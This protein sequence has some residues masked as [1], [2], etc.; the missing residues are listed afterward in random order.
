MKA[1][2]ILAGP[3]R[4]GT[5]AKVMDKILFGLKDKGAEVE[6]LSLYDYDIKPCT[7]CCACE[8]SRECFIEDDHRMILDKMAD[9]DV[10]IFASP[11]YWSNVTSEAKKF[12]DRGIGFFEQG[13][14][15]PVRRES[16]PGK[17]VLISSC[18]APFPFSHMMGV[19]PGAF[20]A[21]KAFF[22]RTSAKLYKFAVPGMMDAEKSQPSE[23]IL[24]KAYSLGSKL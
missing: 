19:M 17:V 22:G 5:T 10:V 6:K 13:M 21:M 11:V 23:K 16:K 2:G 4:D 24:N 9:A 20:R 7:G 14:M 15:G 1:I 12:F 8:K 18:G 3:R